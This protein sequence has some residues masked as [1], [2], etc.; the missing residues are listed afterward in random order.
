MM[1]TNVVYSGMIMI[2]I[3]PGLIFGLFNQGGVFVKLRERLKLALCYCKYYLSL[4]GSA[5]RKRSS[6]RCATS[7]L[8]VHVMS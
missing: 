7:E 1:T 6:Q 8:S 2:I 5:N 3:Q 4:C